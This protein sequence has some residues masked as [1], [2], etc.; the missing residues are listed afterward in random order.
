MRP[1]VSRHCMLHSTCHGHQDARLVTSGH[2]APYVWHTPRSG[3]P[4]HVRPHSRWIAIRSCPR[5]SVPRQSH[6][7]RGA[8]TRREAV[9]PAVGRRS[10]SGPALRSLIRRPR[11]DPG[12][13]RRVHHPVAVGPGDPMAAQRRGCRRV[14]HPVG[15]N[16][17]C[18]FRAQNHRVRGR[19]RRLPSDPALGSPCCGSQRLPPARAH[20]TSTR[21]LIR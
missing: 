5:H 14:L 2:R 15:W 20:P 16:G 10:P 4:L 13:R 11:R 19:R 3:V 6:R 21:R 7:P 9:L 12:D 1:G 8:T 18:R 17:P